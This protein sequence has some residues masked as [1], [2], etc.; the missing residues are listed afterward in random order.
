MSR[1]AEV[2]ALMA[3]DSEFAQNV[4]RDPGPAARHFG[5]TP[6][7]AS[8]LAALADAEE[9][10]GPAQLGARLS[11]SS[12]GSGGLSSLLQSI[13]A[14]EITPDVAAPGIDPT[15]IQSATPLPGVSMPV[16]IQQAPMTSLLPPMVQSDALVAPTTAGIVGPD[17]PPDPLPADKLV[18]PLPEKID[19]SLI[20]EKGAKL[21]PTPMADKDAELDP[22]PI[23][24][25]GAAEPI[26]DGKADPDITTE[27]GADPLPDAKAEPAITT[28][29]TPEPASLGGGIVG[30]D[31]PVE[32]GTTNT[33]T[34]TADGAAA[35]PAAS[36][37]VGP[38]QPVDTP[39]ETSEATTVDADG[40][41]HVG[42]YDASGNLVRETVYA[43][44]GDIGQTTFNADG[45]ITH[46]GVF[47]TVDRFGNHLTTTYAEDGTSVETAAGST[48]TRY[49]DA[50][51]HLAR[52]TTHQSGMLPTFRGRMLFDVT[53]NPDGST[54]S[55]I[56]TW[57]DA[58]G[59]HVMN[60]GSDM[61]DVATRPDGT[62]I[63]TTYD[64]NLGQPYATHQTIDYLDGRHTDVTFDRSGAQIEVSG[65]LPANLTDNGDGTRTADYTSTDGTRRV[66]IY[67]AS[68]SLIHE[69]VYAPNGDV[70]EATHNPDGTITRTGVLHTFD[71]FGNNLTTT[72]AEDGTSVETAA[73]ST[74]T[75]YF[76][77][78][79][80]LTRITSHES[81]ML[82]TFRGR[83]YHDATFNSDGSLATRTY[84]WDDSGAHHVMSWP[85]G[86]DLIDVATHPDGT[87]TRTTYDWNVGQPY[88]THQSIDALDGRHADVTFDRSGA[89]IDISGSPIGLTENADGTRTSDTTAADGTRRVGIYDASGHLIRQNVY[90]P[91]GDTGHILYDADGTATRVG[92]FHTVDRFGNNLTTTYAVDGTSTETSSVGSTRHFDADGHLT[93]TR[94]V[95]SG[96]LPNA[97][98]VRMQY[99]ATFNPDG[100]LATRTYT[101]DDAG[102]HHVMSWPPGNALV[103]VATQPDGTR[104][105]TTY[106]WNNGAPYIVGAR[107]L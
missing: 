34:P 9:S 75:R 52:V 101:W 92:V 83:M 87:I 13:S 60:W 42:T 46:S 104:I 102:G 26:P 41:R 31:Q 38:D 1:L 79:G 25:K 6:D 88:A 91:N 99:D 57:D 48:T 11:K 65:A 21:D 19:P 90:A 105:Q 106:T 49:F 82:P 23:A 8:Q 18:E 50:D 32:L 93:D 47:H 5:L 96:M 84:T 30:P 61:V 78:T 69:T 29:K 58:T 62:V 80:H 27:K 7:E 81:G 95:V 73:G 70:G 64:W 2:V 74:T 45:T 12:I 94:S 56:Y 44:N 16:E 103:D 54:A 100:S 33:A 68:G 59:H 51:G 43:P 28:E 66:G 20:A 17:A 37:I 97:G 98:G 53:Y 14:P 67:D 39:S 24:E 4:R 40:N 77:A 89:Q 36:E 35:S 71:Q 3:T 15:Q 76:D 55:Q 72:Y 63:Q 22:Y 85:A 86:D 10:S 107:R